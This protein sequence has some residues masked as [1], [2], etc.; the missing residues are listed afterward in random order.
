M[1]A[2]IV[3]VILYLCFALLTG[4]FLLR[5]IREECRPSI[6]MPVLLIKYLIWLIPILLLIPVIRVIGT[7]YSSFSVPLLESIRTVVFEY[8]VGQAFLAAVFLVIGLF[9]CLKSKQMNKRALVLLLLLI[10]MAS[11]SSHGAA[12]AGVFGFIGNAMH[13]LAVSVWLGTL[14]VVAW[15]S[16]DWNNP[17]RF[18]RWF[19]LTAVVSV[20]VIIISGFVLMAAIV[21]EYVQAWL[22]SYGQLLFI[23]HLLFLPLLAFGFHHLLLG[24]TKWKKVQKQQVIRTFQIETI[25]AF[26]IFLISAFMTEQTPPHEVVQTMQTENVTWLMQLFIGN[27]IRTID[28][29]ISLLTVSLGIVACILFT[30]AMWIVIR[31]RH[32]IKSASLFLLSVFVLYTGAMLSV[33]Q[34]NDE[35]DETVYETVEKAVSQTYDP[36]AEITILL[37][38]YVEEEVHVVYTVNSADLVAEKLIQVE[39]GYMRL[40][41]AMLT[42]GGTAVIDEQQKIRTFR[43]TSGNWHNENFEYTYVTFGII[44]EPIDTARVQ[45]H[46]E[47]GS[48]IAQLEKNTFI[49]VVSSNEEWA[50]QHPIDFLA[51][52]GR[53]IETY[54][55]NVME[56]GVYCH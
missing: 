46:Y 9:I 35:R 30:R 16:R 2:S 36:T 53:V 40:P 1:L 5:N 29:T 28:F 4:F 47:G 15:F 17:Y 34:G 14:S 39:D 50:D 38:D 54:A 26:V 41:A 44:Y 56:E 45:I 43:V 32:Y 11:W 19:S 27:Q 24:F 20:I 37:T 33:E 22:L 23:K 55:R 6:E 52:S 8:S 12:V 10:V 21:P 13:L 51:E 49:N 25:W 42:I 18:F 3:N 48:Y 31:T 7:L